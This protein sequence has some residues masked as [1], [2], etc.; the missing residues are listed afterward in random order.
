MKIELI[1]FLKNEFTREFIWEFIYKW[2]LI[3]GI[4][5][6]IV[7]FNSI[8]KTFLIWNK[9]RI[10][11]VCRVVNEFHKILTTKHNGIELKWKV[12]NYTKHRDVE[13]EMNSIVFHE[14]H[15]HLTHP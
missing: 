14:N 15:L 8:S 3:I 4:I 13:L 1:S 2:T 6:E 10:S 9:Y 5:H 7:E 11:K 12:S